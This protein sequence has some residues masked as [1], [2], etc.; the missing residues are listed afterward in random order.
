[1]STALIHRLAA[2]RMPRTL[3]TLASDDAAA[4]RADRASC[5]IRLLAGRDSS[6]RADSTHNAHVHRG[7]PFAV[8]LC[9]HPSR[10]GASLFTV[11]VD[12]AQLAAAGWTPAAAVP[13][14]FAPLDQLWPTTGQSAMPPPRRAVADLDAWE[15][16][17]GAIARP[18]QVETW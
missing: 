15:T 18:G 10:P 14:P 17:G 7:W 12:Q 6:H 8:M 16:D 5:E 3:N 4:L 11:P 2:M 9:H 13:V 1:M